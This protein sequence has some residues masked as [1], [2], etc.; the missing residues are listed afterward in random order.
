[1]QMQYMEEIEKQM[2]TKYNIELSFVL[3]NFADSI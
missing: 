2:D 1:M 3:S